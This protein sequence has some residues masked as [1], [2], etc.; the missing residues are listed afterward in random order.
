MI[1]SPYELHKSILLDDTYGTAR[2]LQDFVLYQYE[3]GRYPFDINQHI[4]GF[5]NRHRQIY[6]DLKQWFWEN[7]PDLLLNEIAE[8]IIARRRAEAL[9][10][11]D[12]IACLRAMQPESYPAEVGETPVDAYRSAIEVREMFHRRYVAEGILDE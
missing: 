5:D 1:Q 10:N 12:E 3:S 4:G 6:S 7:G 8:T 11:L 2:R 9:A